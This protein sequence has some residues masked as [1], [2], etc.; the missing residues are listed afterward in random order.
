VSYFPE[1]LS[2]D[3]KRALAEMDL[4]DVREI[5]NNLVATMQVAQHHPYLTRISSL[6]LAVQK[7]VQPRASA[8][9]IAVA[10]DMLTQERA[11]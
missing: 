1:D 3:E 7:Q 4:A 11:K 9:M 5:I 6:S 10:I 2:R 8:L